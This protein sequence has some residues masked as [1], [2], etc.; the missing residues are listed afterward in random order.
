MVRKKKKAS[1]PSGNQIKKTLDA[2]QRKEHG[3]IK[4]LKNTHALMR[5]EKLIKI[6]KNT[7]GGQT[8]AMPITTMLDGGLII[9]SII[10]IFPRHR[11]EHQFI[12]RK[13]SRIML[14]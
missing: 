8:E 1:S 5:L 13:G 6:Q 2:C 14:L 7:L 11:L 10:N 3:W 9:K 4:F 12:R